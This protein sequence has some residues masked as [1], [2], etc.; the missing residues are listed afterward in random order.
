MQESTRTNSQT[1]TASHNRDQT[2]DAFSLEAIRIEPLDKSHDR[3]AFVCTN[4]TIQNY[5]RN[6]ARRNNDAYMVRVFV[7]CQGESRSV[8]GYYYLALTSYKISEKN[9]DETANKKFE[10]VEAVPAVYLGMIGV[11]A[12]Y[13]RRGIGKQLM[14]D[15]IERTA[16]IA[17]HAGLYALTLDALEETVAAYYR[18]Q[19]G[20]QTFK[21]GEKRIGDVSSYP[22]DYGG[23][24]TIR[25][26][27]RFKP[28]SL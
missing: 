8:L 21:A 23:D 9:L 10:R 16:Q 17:Q 2:D 19:F 14:R 4:T 7:A 18:E 12:E 26:L 25:S 24:S 22:D 15:A 5:C 13:Q 11:H 1:E 6:N 20:F 28:I 3:G 27:S